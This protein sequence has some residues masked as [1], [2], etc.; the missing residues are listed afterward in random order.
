MLIETIN[1]LSE[2]FFNNSKSLIVEGGNVFYLALTLISK[3]I[4]YS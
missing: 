4:Y 1:P 3:R 2:N